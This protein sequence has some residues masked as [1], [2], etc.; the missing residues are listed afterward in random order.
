MAVL[1]C[2]I[3]GGDTVLDSKTGIA[4]CE[5]CGTRQ[6]MPLFTEESELLLYESGNNYLN[7]SEYDK[8]ENVFNQLITIRPEAAELYWDLVLCKYGVTYVK[9]P[10]NGKYVPTCNRTHFTSVFNDENY[11]KAISLATEEKKALFEADA[12]TVDEIQ[13]GIIAVSKKE[14]PFDIFISYKE[15]DENGNRTRDS[16]EAQKLYEKLT[17]EGYKVFFSR[18]TLEDKIG[19]EYEPYIYAALYSSKVMITLCSRTEYIEAPWVKNEWSRFLGFRQEDSSKNLLPLYFDMKKEELPE[20]FALLS[21]YDMTAEGFT[22]ELLRGVKK[23]I[24]S[25]VMKAKRRKQIIKGTLIGLSALLLILGVAAGILISQN[26]KKKEQ[27]KKEK[28]QQEQRLKQDKEYQAALALFE[29]R[30]YTAAMEAFKALG[31]YKDS[32]HMAQR[33]PTQPAYDAAMQL[34][35]EGKYP[36]AAWAFGELG[37]YEDAAEQQARAELSWRRSVAT[38]HGAGDSKTEFYVN[39]NGALADLKTGKELVSPGEHGKVVSLSEPDGTGTSGISLLFE[40]GTAMDYNAASQV[41]ESE[42]LK[43][44]NVIQILPYHWF[45][46]NMALLADGTIYVDPQRLSEY[47]NGSAFGIDDP[48]VETLG[49]WENIVQLSVQTESYGNADYRM[50]LAAVDAEGNVKYCLSGTYGFDT[51]T[52][53]ES[54][55]EKFQNVKRL[56]ISCDYNSVHETFYVNA[57]ALTNDGKV[58]IYKDGVTKEYEERDALDVTPGGEVLHKDGTVRRAGSKQVLAN[59]VVK[60]SGETKIKRSGS[61]L[62]GKDSFKTAVYDEWLTNKG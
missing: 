14:K 30:D 13:K 12:A 62:E 43:G 34:Y 40:D 21:A 19:T 2:K 53:F 51:D 45:L 10:K 42:D 24:P 50:Y 29:A 27:E 49:E 17:A 35:Y 33:C 25:P 18:I 44:K 47:G 58:V 31:D 48:L 20:E 59:D 1:K 32:A 4:I 38:I 3:C 39:Q 16:V 11:K 26:A 61:F 8:A 15:T 9:D 55:G 41:E 22:E 6:A 60:L 5:Y 54:A 57:A 23:L 37:D 7:H 46:G 36:Q 52:F 28:A 56:E